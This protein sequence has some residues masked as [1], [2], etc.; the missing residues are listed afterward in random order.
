MARASVYCARSHDHQ[1]VTCLRR[2]A[3]R[4]TAP[5]SKLAMPCPGIPHHPSTA[6]AS[7]FS[8][9]P[10]LVPG[11]TPHIH[12]LLLFLLWKYEE[13]ITASLCRRMGHE[14]HD[15]DLWRV[16]RIH[17]PL[18]PQ[19]MR[20]TRQTLP[21]AVKIY[22]SSSMLEKWIPT[23][24]TKT[25]FGPTAVTGFPPSSTRKHVGMAVHRLRNPLGPFLQID[26]IFPVHRQVL[27]GTHIKCLWSF[28]WVHCRPQDRSS[29][30]SA[31]NVC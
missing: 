8:R 7:G 17:P 13:M 26:P 4:A 28:D 18:E 11:A 20:R 2:E 9:W 16:I 3:R 5:K 10:G 24:I 30:L 25:D 29:L 6:A 19:S 31:R 23:V 1:K 27:S 15:V 21:S 14:G 12:N 22:S